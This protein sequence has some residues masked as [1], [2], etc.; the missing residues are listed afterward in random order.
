MHRVRPEATIA[1]LKP[2]LVL[3]NDSKAIGIKSDIMIVFEPRRRTQISRIVIEGA[4]AQYTFAALR[5]CPGRSVGRGSAI[6]VVPAILPPFRGI[7]RH[8][9]DTECVRLN[10][11]GVN[12]LL[13][14]IAGTAE[15]IGLVLLDSLAPWISRRRAGSRGVFPL[16]FR[17]KPV[18]VP[19]LLR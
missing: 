4:A 15:A 19:G 18:G 14:G 10:R 3:P 1:A 8:V 6:A 11:A 16:A 2:T 9:V 12:R 17:R 5:L 13:H 7:A